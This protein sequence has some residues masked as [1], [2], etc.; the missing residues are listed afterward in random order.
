[1]YF[2]NNFINICFVLI[3]LGIF[4][5]PPKQIMPSIFLYQS[6]I[7]F[8]NANPLKTL[9]FRFHIRWPQSCSLIRKVNQR[10]KSDVSHREY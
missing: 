6:K 7:I 4:Y 9:G 8:Q 1:M 5:L 10:G 3:L 2:I